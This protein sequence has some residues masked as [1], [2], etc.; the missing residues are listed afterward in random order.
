VLSY[1]GRSSLFCDGEPCTFCWRQLA[2]EKFSGIGNGINVRVLKQLNMHVIFLV[3]HVH[4]RLPTASSSSRRRRSNRPD[5][6]HN[7]ENIEFLLCGGRYAQ[8]RA[9]FKQCFWPSLC[10]LPSGSNASVERGKHPGIL[11][12]NQDGPGIRAGRWDVWSMHCRS[13]KGKN[14]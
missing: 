7:H 4:H 8:L 5:V 14:F 6:H 3:Q 12:K 11:S 10:R 9:L 2:A 1:A 13:G